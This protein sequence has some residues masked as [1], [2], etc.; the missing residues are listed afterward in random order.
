MYHIYLLQAEQQ[1]ARLYLGSTEN[2]NEKLQEH[3][4]GRIPRTSGLRWKLVYQ[5][6][7]LEKS[8]A[9]KR[10]LLLRG[11]PQERERLINQIK[12]KKFK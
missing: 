8:H 5:E 1:P 11:S 9:S 2:L 4:N 7:Y 3:N 10:E 6:A 12:A